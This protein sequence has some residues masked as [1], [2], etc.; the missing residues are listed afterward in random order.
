MKIFKKVPISHNCTAQLELCVS[1]T[2]ESENNDSDDL[3]SLSLSPAALA[4]LSI[5]TAFL[6]E[7][8]Y[9]L[10]LSKFAFLCHR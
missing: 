4:G 1:T 9:L 3:I 2:D 10:V 7:Q 5:I 8:H 6:S